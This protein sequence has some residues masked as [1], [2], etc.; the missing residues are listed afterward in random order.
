MLRA[1][2]L[3]A[4]AV[5]LGAALPAGAAAEVVTPQVVTPQVVK[6]Q[7][8]TPAPVP[9]PAPK[10]VPSPPPPPGPSSAPAPAPAPS[11]PV[12]TP[13]PIAA[14]APAGEGPAQGAQPAPPQSQGDGGESSER[15]WAEYMSLRDWILLRN[16]EYT[17]SQMEVTDEFLDGLWDAVFGDD[18]DTPEGSDDDFGPENWGPGEGM[19]VEPDYEFEG[20]PEDAYDE[21]SVAG[22]P[23]GGK[24]NLED[25]PV[26]QS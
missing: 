17:L 21:D 18:N 19:P 12:V 10:P 14:P 7:V 24:P 23:G 11:A 6:P 2:T 5:L 22:M 4:T 1:S 8:V 16:F 26:K 15:S 9:A 3:T 20:E 25:E 13:A